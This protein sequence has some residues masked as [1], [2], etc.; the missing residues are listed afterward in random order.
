MKKAKKYS[1][2]HK[3]RRFLRNTATTGAGIAVAVTLPGLAATSADYE[4]SAETKSKKGYRLTPHIAAYYET[5]T[6]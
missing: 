5:M 6:S 2:D 4:V 1:L 3:R